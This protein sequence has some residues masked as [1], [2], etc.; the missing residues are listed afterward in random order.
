MDLEI[1]VVVIIIL[2]ILGPIFIVVQ[3]HKISTSL[4]KMAKRGSLKWLNRKDFLRLLDLSSEPVVFRRKREQYSG[5]P[6]W[7]YLFEFRGETVGTKA[8]SDF[9]LPEK[10]VTV[11]GQF[12]R[13]GRFPCRTP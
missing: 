12:A 11:S 2:L 5:P 8:G 4:R 6:L 13:T 1:F 3:L 7:E 10:C 9:A